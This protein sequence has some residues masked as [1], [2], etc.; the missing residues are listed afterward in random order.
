[1]VLRMTD[2]KPILCLDF[3]GVLH[4]YT[5]GWQ[6][7]DVVP[8]PPTPGAMAFLFGAIEHFD[9]Q[10][11]SS[12]SG[13][14]GGIEAMQYWLRNKCLQFWEFDQL[15]THAE[16]ENMASRLL[17]AIT[18]PTEKPPAMVTID[19]RALTFRGAWPTMREL[20][21]FKPW[22]KGGLTDPCGYCIDGLQA[23]GETPCPCQSGKSTISEGMADVID[24]RA[25]Q[26]AEFGDTHDN[27]ATKG[28]RAAAA[29]C[30]AAT[31]YIEVP[32]ETLSIEWLKPG[33]R[34]RNLVKA[35]AILVAEIKRLDRASMSIGGQVKAALDSA[36]HEN[37][38]PHEYGRGAEDVLREI[39][40]WSG[41]QG[42]DQENPQHIADGV[43]AVSRWR[44]DNPE[45]GE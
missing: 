42:F 40:D 7:A 15:A 24:E 33:D 25:K 14:T 38:Y 10:I 44:L 21:D 37:G 8:D 28:Q 5:S 16:C 26:H 6:G 43:Y 18:W 3:D 45:A 41:I 32:P 36:T 35:A 39:H 29:T 9:V 34:R 4:S 11:Y 30:Y 1:M 2:T 13:Q 31:G 12:R 23:D 22:N 17:A 19:D 20:L 27:M